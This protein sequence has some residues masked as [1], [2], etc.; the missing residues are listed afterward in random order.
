M[1]EHA[2]HEART[3]DG[4]YRV[5]LARTVLVGFGSAGVTVKILYS[6]RKPID[7]GARAYVHGFMFGDGRQ[8]FHLHTLQRHR[9][10]DAGERPTGAGPAR[11]EVLDE[12]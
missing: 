5:A 12:R 9:A 10:P 6:S 4:R 7:E 8:H 3:K 2:D 11:G 1:A